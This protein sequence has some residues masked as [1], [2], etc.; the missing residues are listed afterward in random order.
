MRAV[1]ARPGSAAEQSRRA[2]EAVRVVAIG[3]TKLVSLLRQ[4]Y[5]AGHRCFGENYVQEFV[6]KAPQLPEDI[7]WH[8]VGHLQSNKV[9]SLV[10][11]QEG[12]EEMLD[13]G[14]EA[15]QAEEHIS[16]DAGGR[17]GEPRIGGSADWCFYEEIG[18]HCLVFLCILVCF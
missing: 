17:A 7:R 16:A 1:L 11:T 4:L 2:A 13:Q 18:C 12:A 15:L 5:D 10:G 8:F 6:T 9:K 14:V 3:K